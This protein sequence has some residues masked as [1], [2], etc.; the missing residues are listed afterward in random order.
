MISAKKRAPVATVRSGQIAPFQLEMSG[1]GDVVELRV[2][3]PVLLNQI[4]LRHT[5]SSAYSKLKL[6]ARG[7]V[8]VQ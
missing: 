1:T 2:G 5:K 4:C 7:A 8:A 6:M 3:L